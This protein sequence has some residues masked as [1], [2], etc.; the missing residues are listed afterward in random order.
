[1]KAIFEA[2]QILQNEETA[3]VMPAAIRKALQLL[4]SP[5][6]QDDNLEC[7]KNIMAS[8]KHQGTNFRLARHLS[9][10]LSPCLAIYMIQLKINED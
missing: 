2:L 9:L 10:P 4:R 1:M 7:R 5:P 8:K 6:D 3:S